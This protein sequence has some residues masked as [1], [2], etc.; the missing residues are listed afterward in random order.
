MNVI[1]DNYNTSV[2]PKFLIYARY[3]YYMDIRKAVKERQIK[4][5]KNDGCLISYGIATI[6]NIKYE[7]TY[8]YIY[9]LTLKQ[10]NINKTRTFL[11][12]F[13]NINKSINS[14]KRWI[15]EH[16]N[17][18]MEFIEKE[19]K[20]S[21]SIKITKKLIKNILQQRGYGL[22][23]FNRAD[24]GS[25]K[26]FIYNSKNININ[27]EEELQSACE[28]YAKEQFDK[29][30]QHKKNCIAMCEKRL[31]ECYSSPI[32]KIVSETDNG[33]KIKI[34]DEINI[35]KLYDEL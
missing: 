2:M 10:Y 18:I 16:N 30:I 6:T 5:D 33:Y 11:K 22:S 28:N 35:N 27:N 25:I 8:N 12:L 24:I 34:N 31:E 7:A 14:E 21:K 20:N 19:K 17:E 26:T 4:S 1:V 23:Y 15:D 32:F 13:K 3:P 9:P 29:E